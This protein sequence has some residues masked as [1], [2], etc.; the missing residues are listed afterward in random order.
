MARWLFSST[1][2]PRAFVHEDKVFLRSG[3]FLGRLD[4]NEVWHG[5]YRGEI[6]RGDLLL[7]KKGKGGLSRGTQ[8]TP[9]RPGIPRTPANRPSRSLPGG[10]RNIDS[11]SE[12]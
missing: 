6:V 5:R 3:R 10:Y 9:A 2:C 8:G 11:D 1:G 12:D 7:Y 4:G